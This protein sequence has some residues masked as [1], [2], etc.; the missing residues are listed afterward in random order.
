[1]AS[2]RDEG[3]VY[4]REIQKNAYLKRIP[5]D[6]GGS[7][8][9][10]LGSKKVP[11]KP[12]WTQFCVHNGR[13]PYLEQYLDAV[14]PATVSHKPVWRACLRSARHV[15]ASVKPHCGDQYDF[16]VDTD[17]GAVR[18]LA[19]DWE[20]MQDWVSTL[21]NTLHELKILGK[22]ENV[23]CAGPAP[24]APRA[25][26]RDPTSPLP[27]TPP[28]P[29][30]RVPGIELT[31]RPPPPQPTPQPTPQ[32]EPVDPQ[33]LPQTDSEPTPAPS[34]PTTPEI[35]ISNWDTP[36]SSLPSTSQVKSEPRKSVAKICGQNI[37]LDDSIFNRN[38]T[39]S[40]DDFFAEIDRMSDD[41]Y[42]QRVLVSNGESGPS[43]AGESSNH[44]ATNITVIQVSNKEP[45]HTAIPVM[46]PEID[47]FDFEFKQNLTITDQTNPNFVNIVNTE[48]NDYG[49]TFSKD[50]DYGHLSLTTTV[51]LT[52]T[53]DSNYPN[54][55]TTSNETEQ[56]YERLCM[57]STSNPKPSPLPVKKL[58]NVEKSRKSSLPNLEVGE[59]T[60][61]YL[62]M[63]NNNTNLINVSSEVN[64]NG[65]ASNNAVPLP[66]TANDSRLRAVER[67]RSQN[68]YDASR[69]RENV[70]RRAQNNSPKRE[71]KNE[72]SD[73]PQNKP[74]WKRGL[75]ELSLLTRLKSIGQ[76]KKES[77]T[78]QN[79]SHDR[80]AVTS[81][82][83]VVHRSRP[84]GRVDATRR[85][86]SSLSNA[87]ETP[88][89]GSSLTP[90]RARQAAALRATQR[91]AAALPATLSLRDPPVFADYD[92]HVWLAWWG[93]GGA[94]AG[95]RAG[96]RVAALRC[97]SP[98]DAAHARQLL[99]L[100][101]AHAVDILFH[102]VPLAKIYVIN[103][104]DQE[105]I[106]LKLDNECNITSVEPG[107]PCARAGLPPPGNWALTEINN[108]PIN[109]LKGGEEEMNR[110]SKHGTEVSVLIQPSALVKKL[111]SA[112]K[113]NKTLLGLR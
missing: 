87:T 14:S 65:E 17:N 24:A 13:T 72:S 68:A 27:P 1:M 56:L 102:R 61:E 89:A 50:S 60:Y 90:L 49:T 112:L 33:P 6:L 88:V 98:R 31:T 3:P 5:N 23:Y 46:G 40:D 20:S 15:T 47:V 48:Q 21:R 81:P 96:D 85:R 110:I 25:A 30:D 10:P 84:E 57:A 22:G 35:D 39:D 41:D 53:S 44:Q 71:I 8:L 69:M 111:R 104:R 9:K 55:S 100:P 95:G 105:S 34:N 12:M 78:R 52:G 63:S 66:T 106:G 80:N 2:S 32:P 113:G 36:F 82:V 59:A 86:S 64:C 38:A 107:S 26:A 92:N 16:L 83:K 75:T 62:F 51:S 94:R 29:P 77:P 43:E 97:R 79:D 58:K 99:A 11:L 42:K 45:P 91:R 73:Q 19:P 70:P 103:K 67:S 76:S 54:F 7:K 93:G 109:L 18:M 28:V 101:H 74:I 108:R 4:Y 37:C